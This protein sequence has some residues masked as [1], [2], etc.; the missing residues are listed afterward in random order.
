VKL[1]RTAA[2]RRNKASGGTPVAFI[3]MRLYLDRFVSPIELNA[4]PFVAG[5]LAMLSIGSRGRRADAARGA[6]HPGA[7]APAGMTRSASE[8]RNLA[9]STVVL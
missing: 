7:G 6:H 3:A 1:S 2:A 9:A 4:A 5:L 8:H